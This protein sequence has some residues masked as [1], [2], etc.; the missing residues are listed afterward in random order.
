MRQAW[1][2]A[3]VNA[4]YG[5]QPFGF[6][7]LAICPAPGDTV[8]GCHCNYG[9]CCGIVFYYKGMRYIDPLGAYFLK[10]APAGK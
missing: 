7:N 6:V 10:S 9:L 5:F 8:S 2:A 4:I 3:F 1:R